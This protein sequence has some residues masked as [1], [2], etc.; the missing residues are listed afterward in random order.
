M[1]FDFYI[2]TAILLSLLIL[3]ANTY[4]LYRIVKKIVKRKEYSLFG[5]LFTKTWQSYL[6]FFLA[7]IIFCLGL[8][9]LL[10]YKIYYEVDNQTP[11]IDKSYPETEGVWA[12]YK[13][14]I[15]VHFTIPVSTARLRPNINPDIK[16]RWEWEPYF[17]IKE[18]TRK[19]K[20][21]PA[22]TLFP[23][24]RI[25]VYITGISRPKYSENHEHG[26]VF[27]SVKLPEVYM[28]EPFN[29]TKEVA[30]DSQIKLT[31][32]KNNE[33]L[34]DWSY[35]FNPAIEFDIE[36]C[37]SKHIILKPKTEL[38]QSRKYELT[39]LRKAKRIDLDTKT[40]LE[41][42]NPQVVSKITFET[43]KE[44]LLRSFTPRGTGVLQDSKIRIRFM[45]SM[46][47]TS[48]EDKFKIEPEVL[49]NFL[50]EDDKLLYFVPTEKLLKETKYKVTFLE[51]MRNLS[52]GVSKKDIFYEFETIGSVKLKESY[53]GDGQI[54]VDTS[55]FIRFTFD[56]QVDQKSA[57]NL[58][59]I[60]PSVP[61]SFK[62]EGNSLIFTPNYLNF[63]TTYTAKISPGVKAIL[64]LDSEKEF[65]ITFT[66]RS[67]EVLISIPQ[68][69]QSQQWNAAGRFGCNLFAA[70]MVLAYKGYNVD[71]VNLVSEIGFNDQQVDGKWVGDPNKVF[72]GTYN[73]S[74][75]YGV[76]WN[77]LKKVF[78]NRGIATEI[79]SNWNVSGIAAEIEAGHPV[80][81]WRYNGESANYDSDWVAGDGTYVDAINGQH[82]GVVTGF[83]GTPQNPTQLFLNDPWYGPFWV[84]INTF[85]YWWGRLDKHAL[86]VK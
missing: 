2:L 74:W 16:G 1:D 28:S 26:F 77:A 30:L 66:T 4:V 61:G 10:G 43:I 13:K 68:Y 71:I 78:D 23:G 63:S 7:W 45:E 53:P 38:E 83:R 32:N 22:E 64:G 80:I 25:V 14:P 72:V 75:G 65:K 58:F 24:Q 3:G 51:G 82:G 31:L 52:G 8:P 69:Y 81:I 37:D 84:D 67:N 86:I 79:R 41:E 20:F 76:Y 39:V 34:S 44:P 50:W 57:E 54:K 6:F 47:R 55:Q 36:E 19:G 15:E 48:V 59:S 9:A 21:Y 35:S 17:G 46:D 27:D 60:S 12:S 18:L 42:D 11:R 85:N 56:Q 49:G 5:K 33:G 40:V 62:W 73:A 70:K 29:N